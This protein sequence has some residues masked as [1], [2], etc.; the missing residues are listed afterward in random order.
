[1]RYNKLPIIL[2]V[3]IT[4]MLSF[5]LLAVAGTT[6]PGHSKKMD[7]CV[8]EDDNGY[9]DEGLVVNGHYTSVYAFDNNED[10]YWDL[11]DGRIRGTVGSID[12]LEKATLTVCDYVVNYRGDFGNDPFLDSG[13]IQN[14]IKCK[15]YG[16]KHGNT[17]KT[18]N[19][20]IVHE[21]DSRYDGNE[22]IWSTWDYHIHTV[23][24]EG[25]V[26]VPKKHVE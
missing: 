25:N 17:P 22:P 3:A 1:M 13:W 14:H 4:L 20:T 24:G 10:W 15:G 23:N 9:C 16:V 2:I 18:E 19:M 5:S 6:V 12:D 11:G 21:S 26:L 8:D 7:E